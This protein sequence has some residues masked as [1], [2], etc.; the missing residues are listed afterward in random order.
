MNAA[1]TLEIF[2]QEVSHSLRR[3]LFWVQL[4]LVFFFVFMMSIGRAQM[5]SGDARVG[6]QKAWLTSEFA[7]AQTMIMLVSLIYVFF[8]SVAAGMAV[9][10]DDEQ[11]VGELLHATPLRPAEYV[12]GKYLGVLASFLAVLALHVGFA[13]ICNHVL[14]KGENAEFIG[15][16]VITNYLRPLVLFALPTLVLFTGACFA[17]GGL[18]RMPV[19]VF[20]FPI[21]VLLLDAFF[22]WD[23]SPGWLPLWA[24]RVLQFVDPTSLRW[25]EETWLRVDR[26][27]EF[28]NRSPIGLDALV[29]TQRLAVTALGL[30]CVAGFQRHFATMLRGARVDERAA[31]AAVS[32]AARPAPATTRHAPAA[33]ATLA[34]RGSR[35]SA[36]ATVLEVA[37]AE[38]HQLVRAPGLYLFVPLILIQTLLNEY[39]VGAFDTPLLN[40][41]GTLASG[42]M[43]TL[44]LLVCMVLLFYTTESLQ[45]ERASGFASIYYA[46]PARTAAMLAGKALANTVLGLTIVLACFVGCLIVLATQ[47]R[48]PLDPLP[49]AIVWGLLMAPTFLVWTAFVAAVYAASSNRF[50]TYAVG[51]GVMALS[52]WFQLRGHMNWVFNWNL[53]SATRWTD[54]ATFQYDALPLVL[55]RVTWL[56]AAVFL[57]V[58]TVRLFER[59]ERDAT[60]TL[61]R[62]RPSALA[63]SLASL[64]PFLLVPL[65]AGSVLGWQVFRGHE[66]PGAKKAALDYW[67]KNI[68]TWKDAPTPALTGVDVD[69]RFDPPKHAFTLRG[70]YVVRNDGTAPMVRFPVTV[71]PRWKDLK[72][73]ANGAPASTESRAGLVIVNPPTPLAP[74]E[75][76]R[77]GFSYSGRHPDGPSKNGAYDKEF[78]TPSSIVLTSFSGLSFVP[79]L[80]FH[81]DAGVEEGKNDSDPREWPTDWWHGRNPAGLAAAEHWYDVALRVDVPADLQVN[82]TGECTSDSVQ[83]GRR[84]TTWRTDHPVRIFNLVAGHWQVKRREGVAV[85]H[86]ARHAYNVDEMLD[87]LEGAR[88]WY[89]EWFAPY[90]WKSLRLS[91]FA[92]WPTYAQAPA[93]NITFSEHIGFLTRSR[94]EANAAFW[95]A[96][97]EAAH[98]WWPNMAMVADG[99]G[100][101][102]LSEGMAH[103]STLL[104]TE[105]LRGEQQRQAFARQ[106]ET[107]Y[108]RLRRA[109]SER[110]L[111][112]L[113]GRLP[114]DSRIWYDKGGWVLWM[115]HSHVGAERGLAAIR[116]YMATFRDGD[117]HASL[118]DYLAIQRRHAADTTA[119][120][121]FANQWFREVAVP[122][123]IVDDAQL[124]ADGDAWIVT[125]TVRNVG[126]GSMPIEVAAVRGER[127]PKDGAK[128]RD[129]QA[130]S[131][132]VTLGPKQSAKV[133]LRS[134]FQPERLV[135]D[136]EVTVLMLERPKAEVKLSPATSPIAA[137]F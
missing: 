95:I 107:R 2:R 136:P 108:G 51:L 44:T 26:G 121:A 101:D 74:G 9:I 122:H 90:P 84:V 103:F 134:A 69:V 45:R 37:R 119:F 115:L 71:N 75:S 4:V 12:W 127:W 68:Q 66:G 33:L 98:M 28:Y 36:I 35:P 106:M 131:T 46:T 117:D 50:A 20:S 11:K 32:R 1:R 124:A 82:A 89:G 29:V 22:L 62:L 83:G 47:G 27:V 59:R 65:V 15:P 57:T 43:N 58:L 118:E 18:T 120:D 110:A 111:V 123:Y 100:S 60:S 96:A 104:L 92:G 53:W 21:A 25:L 133:R 99:P 30:A 7:V 24:N 137:R 85:F 8:V 13:M 10:R 19:L 14:P 76:M 78:I 81:P 116:E 56:G 125:A 49:F 70:H 5:S 23:W 126:T 55:N 64:A 67:R 72:W 48:V 114:G 94:P 87:A 38:L 40:T 34:M 97:H 135:L 128:G 73:T 77:L 63:G 112:K 54:I 86:D 109:D 61:V 129:W 79:A 105:K 52:G 130:S 91:E 3:P 39:G 16:F 31:A 17:I 80:G 113:D 132:R 102:V 42:M 41:A 6:G 88:R 93:G